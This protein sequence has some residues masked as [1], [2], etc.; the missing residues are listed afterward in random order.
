MRRPTPDPVGPGQESVWGY[1]R[2]PA[3]RPC[4]KRVRVV[5]GGITVVDTVAALR[6][7]ETSQLPAYY[8]PRADVRTDLFTRAP[9]R[10]LCE[11]KG[12]A[13]YWTLAVP[14]SAPVDAVAWS[15][16]DPTPAFEAIRGHLAL[17]AGRVDE[18]WVGDDRVEPNPGD[19]YGG[20]WTPDIVGPFKGG[21]G[22]TWW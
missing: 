2:P 16:E 8:L 5:H 13:T 7:C 18:C 1:P 15:Y 12:M 19:F 11:W 20:W 10:S 6:V 4:A 21:P 9:G 14:G 17:Y 3:I 22:S